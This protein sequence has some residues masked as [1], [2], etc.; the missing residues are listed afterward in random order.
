MTP[1]TPAPTPHRR[2]RDLRRILPLAVLLA[3]GA[4]A[5][6]FAGEYLS[7]AALERNY[8]ALLAWREAHTALA[9]GGYLLAYVLVVAFSVPGAIWLTLLGGLLFGVAAGSALVVVGATVG[10]T[11]VFLAARTA[12]AD[13]LHA[14]ARGW[15]ARLERGFHRGEASF[16]LAMRLIPAV[17]F[18]I[19]NLAPALLGARLS[20][21]VWTTFLGIIPATVV[22]TSVGAGLGEELARGERPD[23]GV[24]FEPH[25]LL[26]LL[27]LAALAAMPAL[28]RRAGLGRPTEPGD[29]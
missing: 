25:I 2:R 15:L 24:I 7:F 23:L 27:G 6:A 13:W 26:P 21:F 4:T 14:R 3:G 29:A 20:T 11:L 17:P 16:L 18:F 12:L 5:V 8:E 1:D 10:A 22:Y 28:L 19:A 9:A